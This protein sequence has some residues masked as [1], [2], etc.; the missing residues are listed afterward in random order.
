MFLSKTTTATSVAGK[1][2][3]E[4]ALWSL[5]YGGLDT[6]GF[7]TTVQVSENYCE[8]ASRPGTFSALKSP[9]Q[10]NKCSQSI[11][12]VWT[13]SHDPLK[14]PT[15]DNKKHYSKVVQFNTN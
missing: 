4:R 5:S 10:E 15:T 2:I 3:L 13:V 9:F 6:C 14:I 11:V 1:L 12:S 7:D 8:D